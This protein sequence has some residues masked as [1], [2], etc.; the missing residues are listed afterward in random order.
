MRR[1]LLVLL[2]LPL[3]AWGAELTDPWLLIEK[4]SRAAHEL[5]YKGVFVQQS[6][7]TV[8][9]MQITHMN[10]GPNGEFA[11]V[12]VLDGAPREV[13]RQGNHALIYHPKREKV[14]IDRRRLQSGFPAVLPRPSSD[15]RANYQARLGD[16]ERVGGHDGRIVMLEPYDK[17][18]Y[19]CKLWID[20]DS[21][22]LLKIALLNDKDEVVEQTAFSQVTLISESNMDWFRPEHQDGKSYEVAPEDKVVQIAPQSSSWTVSQLPP[23]FRK[24]EQVQRMFPGKPHPVDHM[25]FWDGLAAVSLFIE[26]LPRGVLPRVGGYTQGATNVQVNVLNGHQVVVVGEVPAIT[27]HQI[28]NSVSFSK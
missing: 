10:H 16:V 27:V 22:L 7:T 19:R 2:C 14:L 15:L 3:G 17:Y 6:G 26:P 25:V 12:L 9:S 8:H 1:L 4:A 21:G 20:R 23:G 24:T 28:A 5:D 11:R 18:R 13:L